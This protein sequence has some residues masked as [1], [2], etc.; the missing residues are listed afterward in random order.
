MAPHCDDVTDFDLIRRMADDQANFSG[1]RDAWACF[2]SRHHQFLTR[3][4]MSDHKY[5]I[6]VDGVQDVVNH[7]FIKAFDGAKSFNTSED[8]EASAQ[9][10]KSRGWL[11]QIAENIVRDRFRNQLEVSMLSDDEIELLPDT[12]DR[13]SDSHPV[14]ESTRLRL[15]TAGF[16][17]LSDVEQ[18]VLRATMFWWQADKLHQRMPHVAMIELS[19]QIDKSADNIRQIR[20]RAVRKLEKYVNDNLSYE[21]AD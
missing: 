11:V 1:A 3:V 12:K 16:A 10:R 14:P 13:E 21:K 9:A 19:K 7:T 2:Y 5:V 4:C 17:L 15:I 6:G 8:C 20:I 18:T